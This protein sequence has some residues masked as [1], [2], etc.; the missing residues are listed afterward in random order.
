MERIDSNETL[1]EVIA[2]IKDTPKHLK[3]GDPNI[4]IDENNKEFKES[5]A[6]PREF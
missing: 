3:G 5:S 6:E 2:P 4:F 1:E